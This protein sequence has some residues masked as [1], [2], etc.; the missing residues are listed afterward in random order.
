MN[1]HNYKKASDY[2][3]LAWLER[4]IVEMTPYQKQ[5]LRDNETIRFAP[6]EFY[7]RRK[8]VKSFWLRLTIIL[9]PIVWVILFISLPFNFL[10]TGSWGYKY[11]RVKWFDKWR[12]SIGV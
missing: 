11:E 10:F 6:F 4:S 7:K 1:Y 12:N 8:Q 5:K 3:V 2:D 9:M